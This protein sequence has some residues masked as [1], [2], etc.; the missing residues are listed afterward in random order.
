[1]YGTHQLL[2]Y[3][4]ENLSENIYVIKKNTDT[5]SGVS[6]AYGGRAIGQAVSRRLFTEDARVR[7]RSAHVVH[8]SL[9]RKKSDITQK[10][11]FSG[12]VI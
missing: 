9:I 6:K 11:P 7:A 12:E 1:L 10:V 8:I 5:L 2:V 4:D 3:T